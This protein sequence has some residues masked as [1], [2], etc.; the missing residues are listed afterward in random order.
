MAVRTWYQIWKCAQLFVPSKHLTAR[1][2]VFLGWSISVPPKGGEAAT[3]TCRIHAHGSPQL[4][5]RNMLCD[6]GCFF[7]LLIDL[8]DSI[9]RAKGPYM[10]NLPYAYAYALT[11]DASP[12]SWW[13][14]MMI[15][16]FMRICIWLVSG[17]GWCVSCQIVHT[18]THM[19]IVHIRA[20]GPREISQV[21]Q[22]FLASNVPFS[23][24]YLVVAKVAKGRAI[25]V[26]LLYYRSRVLSPLFSIQ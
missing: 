7:D 22:V 3:V 9:S 14:S 23:V 21:N 8:I 25:V 16:A 4:P 26:T 24:A 6:F 19:E 1:G 12:W 5:Y 11:W 15:V 20:I 13:I 18:R 10:Y 17:S 2:K